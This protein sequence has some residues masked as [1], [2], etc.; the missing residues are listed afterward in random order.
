MSYTPTI[1]FDF[2]SSS[3]NN[4]KIVSSI[5][6]TPPALAP[7]NVY[8]E[9][10]GPAG[11]VVYTPDFNT[12]DGVLTFAVPTAAMP[13]VV[14][15]VDS[16]GAWLEGSYTIR[17]YIEVQS[18]PGVYEQVTCTFVLDVKKQGPTDCRISGQVDVA[19]NCH[20]ALM[21]VEE[22]TDYG[23]S[24][25]IDHTL[26]I[27]P[28]TIPGQA[29]P[30]TLTT[31]GYVYDL[32]IT[33]GNVTYLFNIA[34][35]YENYYCNGEV[36]VRED[37]LAQYSEKIVCDRNLC[38]LLLCLEEKL[39]ALVALANNVGGFDGVP[40]HIH[41]QYRL[42]Q[43][44]FFL[45]NAFVSCG[46][47]QHADVYFDKLKEL[48][49]C[50]C[51]CSDGNAQTPVLIV[52][53]CGTPGSVTTITQTTSYLTVNNTSPGVFALGLS[54]NFINAVFRGITGTT[55]VIVAFDAPSNNWVISLD[56]AFISAVAA[57][58][59]TDVT[60]T[61][62]GY[63]TITTPS[64][65]IRQID[66]DPQPIIDSFGFSAWQIFT[67]A[68]A[69]NSFG[70][71]IDFDGTPVPLRVSLNQ[72]ALNEVRIHG[73]FKYDAYNPN[74]AFCIL[75]A[76]AWDIPGTTLQGGQFLPCFDGSGEIVGA[77]HFLRNGANSNLMFTHN[78]MYVQNSNIFINGRYF[79]D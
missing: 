75:I 18:I 20:C 61:T 37:L 43:L 47:W 64:A 63:I 2:V 22:A 3:A 17:F 29:Q 50:S 39:N 13:L 54:Q 16:L 77:L 65:G 73:S 58:G 36:T 24:T 78:N 15:P 31:V 41:D 72:L 33:H 19:V 30:T 35:I 32:P 34:T 71:N 10:I 28:P 27:V 1:L 11:I 4:G 79:L 9:V 70:G 66:F 67:N 53:D 68:D 6:N 51:G 44:N 59:I 40:K 60:T 69:N 52:P 21:H 14:V 56:P 8:Y 76:G 5:T 25:I 38:A 23:D 48:L 57:S 49:H 74:T 26:E 7:L 55:P 42:L 62:P 45:Y 46:D 12:P